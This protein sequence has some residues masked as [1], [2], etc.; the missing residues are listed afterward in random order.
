MVLPSS[1]ER[2]LSPRFHWTHAPCS[3]FK[4]LGNVGSG[5]GFTLQ[6]AMDRATRQAGIDEK[7]KDARNVTSAIF[8]KAVSFSSLDCMHSSADDRHNALVSL[9]F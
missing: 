3:G 9:C 4:T 1:F 8:G 5:V 7:R 2:V 6:L